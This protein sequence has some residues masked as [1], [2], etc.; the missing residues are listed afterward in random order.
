MDYS[1]KFVDW[2]LKGEDT[3]TMHTHLEVTQ[4]DFS[5]CQIL[6]G[7]LLLLDFLNLLYES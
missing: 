5:H 4:Y 2:L 6:M 1:S 7:P 3:K